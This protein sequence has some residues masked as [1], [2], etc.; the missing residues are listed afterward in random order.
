M[1]V[2]AHKSATRHDIN[3]LD[4]FDLSALSGRQLVQ[5]VIDLRRWL[6]E[7]RAKAERKRKLVTI[8][9]DIAER[10]REAVTHVNH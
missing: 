9:C 8:H 7:H 10:E 5:M 2:M 4:E 1:T 3:T 6:D